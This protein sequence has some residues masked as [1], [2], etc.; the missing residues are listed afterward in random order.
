[1]L[2]R[3][4]QKY[5]PQNK[6]DNHKRIEELVKKLKQKHEQSEPEEE[7]APSK[8]EDWPL[9]DED[10]PMATSLEAQP[11]TEEATVT[12]ATASTTAAAADKEFVLAESYETASLTETTKPESSSSNFSQKEPGSSEKDKL[13][14]KAFFATLIAIFI[15]FSLGSLL[16][17]ITQQG[18]QSGTAAMAGLALLAAGFI[19]SILALVRYWPI[20]VL[21]AIIGALG[22]SRDSVDCGCSCGGCL[23]IIIIIL[24]LF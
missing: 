6:G 5:Q 19:G 21:F 12:S 3:L 15:A 14:F 10:E 11:E 4:R 16:T 18:D 9:K 23:M 24:L 8:Q 1:M 17:N 7:L 2:E 20:L 13:S 22:G